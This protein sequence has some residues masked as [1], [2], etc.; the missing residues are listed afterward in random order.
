[1]TKKLR[2]N[3]INLRPEVIRKYRYHGG[4]NLPIRKSKYK[5]NRSAFSTFESHSVQ[6]RNARKKFKRDQIYETPLRL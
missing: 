5:T 6:V 1:M 2:S 3:K 4:E